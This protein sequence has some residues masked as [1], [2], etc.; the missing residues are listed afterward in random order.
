MLVVV[1]TQVITA[2]GGGHWFPYAVPS[3]W[4]GMGGAEAAA[5]ISPAGLL[6]VP[7]T[8]ALGIVATLHWWSTFEEF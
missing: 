7:L 4:A 2:I 5:D 8:A 6:S 1:A 3:L